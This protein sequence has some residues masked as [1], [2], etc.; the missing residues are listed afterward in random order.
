MPADLVTLLLDGIARTIGEGRRFS[1]GWDRTGGATF[2][3]IAGDAAQWT[4]RNIYGNYGRFKLRCDDLPITEPTLRYEI[5]GPN[6]TDLK[7]VA[8]AEFPGFAARLAP[9]PVVGSG[10]AGLSDPV[11]ITPMT[12]L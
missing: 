2:D 5:K 1:V 10:P 12:I 11:G 8:E 6:D 9:A 3:L 7:L 4:A